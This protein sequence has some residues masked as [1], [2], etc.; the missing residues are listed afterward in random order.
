MPTLCLQ[1]LIL[2]TLDFSESS[3]IVHALTSRGTMSFLARGS[4]KKKNAFQGPFDVLTVK[5]LT[6]SQKARQDSLHLLQSAQQSLWFPSFHHDLEAWYGAEMVREILLHI[7][8]PAHEAPKTLELALKALHVMSQGNSP[9]PA[10]T[11]FVALLLNLYGLTPNL[12]HCVYSGKSLAQ[13]KTG[14]FSFNDFG[15]ISPRYFKQERNIYK[16]NSTFLNFFREIFKESPEIKEFSF[17]L[18]RKAFL[19]TVKILEITLARRLILPRLLLKQHTSKVEE[20]KFAEK[21]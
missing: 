9:I 6:F 19:F 3:Q 20:K 7:P 10:G 11:R 21:A 14:F 17:Y 1:A 15:L 5:E 13:E 18:W 4:K 8:I 2:K 12:S 16:V